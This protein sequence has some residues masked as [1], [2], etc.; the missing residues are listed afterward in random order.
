MS[1]NKKPYN[2]SAFPSKTIVHHESAMQ[3]RTV[4]NGQE[5][6]MTLRDYF[7]SETIQCPV[8]Y[9]PMNLY[10]WF[11]WAFGFSYKGCNRPSEEIAFKAYEIA[12]AMLKQREL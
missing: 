4:Y 10:H 1:E 2:P 12:D 5:E 7:A 3:C 9:K 8:D 6:G 11:R